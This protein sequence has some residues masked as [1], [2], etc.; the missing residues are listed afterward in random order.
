MRTSFDLTQRLI[1]FPVNIH[2]PNGSGVAHLALDTGSTET[3]ISRRAL[4]AVGINP[5]RMS[6]GSVPV[7]TG[8]GI[9]SVPLVT[10][11]KLDALGQ[12]RT[13]FTVQAH[14]LPPSLPIDGLL[15]LDFIRGG[16]LVVDFRT[17]RIRLT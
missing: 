4:L 13:G 3:T 1:V 16:R 6:K 17:G 2:G 5:A 7:I 11:D 10:L 15:G 9:I 12:E 14:T 8:N